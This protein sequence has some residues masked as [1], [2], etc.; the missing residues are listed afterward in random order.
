MPVSLVTHYGSWNRLHLGLCLLVSIRVFLTYAISGN[1]DY[2]QAKEN[3]QITIYDFRDCVKDY[4]DL[5][6]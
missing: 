2:F 4:T 6:N 5:N 3:R 1:P